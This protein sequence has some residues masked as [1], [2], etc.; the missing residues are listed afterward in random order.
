MRLLL[1]FVLFLFPQP[2]VP[3]RQQS[4]WLWWCHTSVLT[5]VYHSTHASFFPYMGDSNFYSILRAPN[6]SVPVKDNE[7]TYQKHYRL[8][9][10]INHTGNLNR[11]HYTL[12]IKIPNSKACFTWSIYLKNPSLSYHF[13]SLAICSRIYLFRKILKEMIIISNNTNQT[14]LDHVELYH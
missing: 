1:S 13:E 9:A 7:V 3:L 4:K 12:F 10:T 6:I 5:C 2:V 8:I 14:S 11:G